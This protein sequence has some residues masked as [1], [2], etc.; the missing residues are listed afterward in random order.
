MRIAASGRPSVPLEGTAWTGG[1]LA[2]FA[3]ELRFALL[4]P[5]LLAPHPNFSQS[6]PLSPAQAIAMLMQAR[7]QQ[8]NGYAKGSGQVPTLE[9]ALD[10][11]DWRWR[12]FGALGQ[13]TLADTLESL[14]ASFADA[15]DEASRT[16]AAVTLANALIA[17][18]QPREALGVVEGVLAADEASPVDDAWLR[19]QRARALV[20]VGDIDEA[21]KEA[22]AVQL[23]RATSSDDV[24]ATA[25]QGV[26]AG[27]LFDHRSWTQRDVAA[28][29]EGAD[30]AA[31]WW[32]TEGVAR[33]VTAM[34]RRVIKDWARDRSVAIVSTDDA[35]DQLYAAALNAG[36]LGDHGSWRSLTSLLGQD[37][38][39]RL[40]RRARVRD[41]VESVRTLR[42][43]GD[44]KAIELAID[45][46]TN[47]GPL[48]AVRSAA[49][50]VDLAR[51]TRTT[52][53]ADLALLRSSGDVLDAETAERTC[54]WLE[55][56]IDDP[57]PLI[58]LTRS[59]TGDPRLSPLECLAEVAAAAPERTIAIV[60]RH[61]S[62]P[63]LREPDL[64]FTAWT[65]LVATIPRDAWTADALDALGG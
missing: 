52:I 15:P 39:I 50:E 29:L 14:R 38:L 36:H 23:I 49:A 18:S 11:P 57:A 13:L 34:A 51:S 1:Q 54:D 9:E 61:L 45:R 22:S 62:T 2:K 10:W 17:L 3:D 33:G 24:T 20:D 43:A 44:A 26:A 46:L 6:E 30:R 42:L 32:R 64:I 63:Q 59:E 35:N 4:V 65:R 60:L 27:I 58:K 8:L 7:W 48:A 16:A 40:D 41:V 28:L 47:D 55:A 31:H 37:G 12:F 19:V 56:V 5:R 25:L 53:G 21:R